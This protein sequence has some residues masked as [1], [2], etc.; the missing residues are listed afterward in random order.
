MDIKKAY[1]IMGISEDASLNELEDRFLILIKREKTARENSSVQASENKIDLDQLNEAYSTLKN[2]LHGIEFPSENK[3][4]S[5]PFKEKL[6]HIFYYYKFHM[7]GGIILILLAS[8]VISTIIDR[9]IEKAQIEE[10]GPPAL[11]VMF[12]G[13]FDS[14][15]E[16]SLQSNFANLFPDWNHI[17]L[18]YIHSSKEPRSQQD[19]GTVVKNQVVMATS[20]PDIIIFDQYHYDGMVTLGS[21]VRLDELS[22][23][24]EEKIDESKLNFNQVEEDD[25]GYLYGVDITDSVVFDDLGMDGEKVAII[26]K[27]SE[28]MDTALEFI[29]TTAT[30]HN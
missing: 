27:G 30:Q 15:T 7:I 17:K 24:I 29:K 18:E 10:Q 5:S 22:T 28:K 21:F 9:Q 3:S 11:H 8:S 14:E 2:H 12:Y 23:D 6:D 26:R 13:E 19:Y 25:R 1:T 20:K 4:S 16:T